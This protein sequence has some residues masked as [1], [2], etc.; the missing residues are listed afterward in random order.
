MQ[1]EAKNKNGR[2]YPLHVLQREAERFTTECVASGRA[3]GELSHPDSPS[4]NLERVSH[5]II[6]LKQEGDN[7]MGKA[8]ILNTPYGKIVKEFLDEGV[9]LGVS[10]RGVGSLLPRRD[11]INEVQDDFRLCTVDIVADPSAPEAF[12]QGILEGVDWIYQNGVFKVAELEQSKKLIENSNK[13][14]REQI[15]ISQFTKYINQLKK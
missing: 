8:K 10:T 6:E 5:R 11:G 15:I 9:T 1:A 7:F 2:I 13:K 3:L 12:V 14:E 4:V